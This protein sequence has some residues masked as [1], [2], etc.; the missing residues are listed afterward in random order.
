MHSLWPAWRQ[1]AEGA[2]AVAH[3]SSRLPLPFLISLILEPGNEAGTRHKTTVVSSQ[4]VIIGR[5]R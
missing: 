3:V 4:G 1:A 2:H 5:Q